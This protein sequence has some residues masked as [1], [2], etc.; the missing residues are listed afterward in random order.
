MSQSSLLWEKKGTVIGFAVAVLV[1]GALRF[2][3]SLAGVPDRITTFSSMTV[4]IIVG[5]LY[6]AIVCSRWSD[7]LLATYALFLPYTLVDVVA[8]GYTWLT[9]N[10]TIFQRHEHAFGL[11]VGEH[12]SA[13]AVSGL[14][15]LPL[16]TFVLMSG[17][18]WV[19]WKVRTGR[20]RMVP[21]S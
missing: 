14:T 19:Y 20:S 10:P 5:A 3:L 17:I 2:G 7:R 1:V 12:L 15:T 18:A 9:G 21:T 4:V 11:T 6:F 8:L 16:S 13:M